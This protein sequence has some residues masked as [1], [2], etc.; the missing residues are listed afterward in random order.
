MARASSGAAVKEGRVFYGWWVVTAAFVTTFVGFGCAYTF[1]AFLAPLQHQFA[2]SRGTISLIFSLAGFLYFMLGAASGLLADRFG[3]RALCAVGACLIAVGMTGAASARTLP[4]VLT[5][6]GLGVGL[7]IGCAYVPA[8]GAVQR[9][10]SRRRGL[11]SGIAVSGIGVGTLVMPPVASGLI[12]GFGWRAAYLILAAGVAALGI[13]AA[14]VMRDDPR[15]MGLKPDGDDTGDSSAA[16]ADGLGLAGAIRSSPFVYLY[17]G[18]LLASVGAFVPFVHLVPF[19]RNHG[20]GAQAA[21][22]L[23]AL[24][25]A[26]SA[27]ARP[28]LGGLADRLGRVRL[29]I[30]AVSVMG[31]SLGLWPLAGSFPALALFAVVFGVACGGWVALLPAWVADLFGRKH[32]SGIIGALYTSV[33]F[34]TLVGPAAAGFA[35]DW[36]G[37]YRPAIL[38]AAA[39]QIM[40][41]L[42]IAQSARLAEL[43]KRAPVHAS[44]RASD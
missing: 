3:V 19:A 8:M 26:G 15:D 4:E 35:Y 14:L 2:A 11:A 21:V 37:S 40:G 12:E 13:I 33:A 25:G 22:W 34:G 42:S 27:L 41:A 23:V 17:I 9:W 28:V 43:K 38:A 31:A 32:I 6:Y 39:V 16:I 1:G 30:A 20:I 10:F 7:G 18:N 36:I 24:A 44:T 29:L 5:A